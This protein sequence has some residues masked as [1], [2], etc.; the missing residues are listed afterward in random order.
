MTKR[1]ADFKRYVAYFCHANTDSKWVMNLINKLES[2]KYGIKCAE[3]DRDF[4]CGGKYIID[5]FQEFLEYSHW[6]IVVLSPEFVQSKWSMYQLNLAVHYS[7]CYNHGNIVPLMIT[8]VAVPDCLKC[9]EL[10]DTREKQWLTQL[11]QRLRFPG[12]I[13]IGT[14]GGHSTRRVVSE[15]FHLQ[16]MDTLSQED[17]NKVKILKYRREGRNFLDKARRAKEPSRSFSVGGIMRRVSAATCN[18]RHSKDKRRQHCL[19]EEFGRKTVIGSDDDGVTYTVPNSVLDSGNHAKIVRLH[20]GIGKQ[21]ID[22]DSL[23]G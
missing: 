1:N 8:P 3:Y 23:L 11:L 19:S 21:R 22:A 7:I 18:N 12:H 2:R 14:L 16:R 15:Q 10:V 5:L 20:N 17:F 13:S 9:F 4:S 6:V